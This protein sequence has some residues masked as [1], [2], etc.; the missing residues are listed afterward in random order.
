MK[1]V[2]EEPQT[3]GLNSTYLLDVLKRS[4]HNFPS[5]LSSEVMTQ[6]VTFCVFFLSLKFGV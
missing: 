2:S 6:N 4:E 3:K 5:I 1:L